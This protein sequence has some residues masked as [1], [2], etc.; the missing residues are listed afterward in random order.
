MQSFNDA[1]SPRF[2][3][4]NVRKLLFSIELDTFLPEGK[5]QL[6]ASKQRTLLAVV[7]PAKVVLA[8][9]IAGLPPFRAELPSKHRAR[10]THACRCFN[11]AV[12]DL[13]DAR[14]PGTVHLAFNLYDIGDSPSDAIIT[15]QLAKLLPALY[16]ARMCSISI[17]SDLKP[18]GTAIAAVRAAFASALRESDVVFPPLPPHGKWSIRPGQGPTSTELRFQQ[19]AASLAMLSLE[20]AFSTEQGRALGLLKVAQVRGPHEQGLTPVSL[21]H[22]HTLKLEDVSAAIRRDCLLSL[23]MP[24]L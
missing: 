1:F 22:L 7:Q 19:L 13:L 8:L 17:Q 15:A 2:L 6:V 21:P 10:V 3:R 20:H 16:I 23:S 11:E 18:G 24:A 9:D 4:S 14:P 12:L 5:G